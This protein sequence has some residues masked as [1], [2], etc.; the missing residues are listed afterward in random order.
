M[1]ITYVRS[2][3]GKRDATAIPPAAL[4][5]KAQETQLMLHP[6]RTHEWAV[7]EPNLTWAPQLRGPIGWIVT[8][9]PNA[10]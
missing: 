5:A 6:Q 1:A 4:V 8:F 7:T 9:S 2:Y 3:Y 10:D